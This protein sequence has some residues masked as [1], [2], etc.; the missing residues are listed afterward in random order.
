MVVPMLLLGALVGAGLLLVLRGLAVAPTPL[1]KLVDDLHRPRRPVGSGASEQRLIARFAGPVDDRRSADLAVCDRTV[2]RFAQDRF[3]W[4]LMFAAAPAGIG[5]VSAAAGSPVGPAP[6]VAVA[7]LVAA[8]SGWLYAR[9]DL[10]RDAERKRREFRHAIGAYLELV[11]ILIAGGRGVESALYDAVELGQGAP[12]RQLRTALT[13]AQARREPPWRGLGQ[14]GRQL[15]VTALEELESSMT[16]A[17]ESGARVRE[18]LVAKAR[19]L[20][21]RDLGEIEAEAQARSETMVF[22]VAAMFL[23]FIVLVGYPAL[24]AL[25][26]V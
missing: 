25:S 8:V 11:T 4:A 23:A 21:I 5:V 14:L 1:A 18:S 16:L 26:S 17:G 20:R 6:V 10:H 12:F 15:R 9:A 22:P 3:T 24:Q 7:T 13:A 2:G 19:A